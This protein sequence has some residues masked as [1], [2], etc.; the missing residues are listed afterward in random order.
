MNTC[1]SCGKRINDNSAFFCHNCG[2]RLEAES[3]TRTILDT[4]VSEF[5]DTSTEN[6]SVKIDKRK[7]KKGFVLGLVEILQKLIIFLQLCL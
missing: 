5:S 2:Y 7:S 3:T 4:P 1:P 6:I